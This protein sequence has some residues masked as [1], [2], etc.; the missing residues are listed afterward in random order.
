VT[1]K[2]SSLEALEL[3]RRNPAGFD[4]VITDMTMPSM[5]GDILSTEMK[6]IR[7]DLPVILCT[8][9]SRKISE[10]QAEEIGINAFAYKPYTKADFAKTIRKV[11]DA[12]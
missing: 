3:F 2:T 10:Q 9:Y 6:K 5:T 7:P 12:R 1:E 4:L 8:G 11:L